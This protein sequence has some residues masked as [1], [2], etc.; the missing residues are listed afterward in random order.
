MEIIEVDPFDDALLA[1]WHGVYERSQRHQREH[2]SP[3]RLAEVVAELRAPGSRRR[4]L[5]FAGLVDGS[6]VCN[7][8]LS[9]PQLDNL[10]SAV[11]MVDT[12]PSLRHRGYGAAMLAHL[13]ERAAAAGRSLLNTEAFYPYDGPADGAGHDHAD[14]LTHRGYVFGLGDVHR[15][16]ALP[17][18]AGMLDELAAE[19]EPHHPA[20]RIRTWRGRVPDELVASFAT[21]NASL[22]TEAPV[23]E[24]EREPE[25]A[26]VDAVREEESLRAAQG[27]VPYSAVALDTDGE[28]RAFTTVMTTVHEPGRCYQ[29]GTVVERAHR[30]HRL[31]VAIKVANL[32]ALAQHDPPLRE[33]FTYNA[34]VNGHMVAINDLLGFEPVERL[35]EFQKRI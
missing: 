35:G 7:G 22:M 16:L 19:A 30:G 24:I 27:R 11:V 2:P 33:L 12:D 4:L 8:G 17:V 21:I 14:F 15:R 25:A 3:W 31:G 29:W 13:E 5:G 26:D 1:D 18:A 10:A 9:L 28:V 32:R 34:E 23:G 20:Y 6:V